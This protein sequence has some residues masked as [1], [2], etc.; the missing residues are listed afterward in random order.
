[1]GI[2][3]AMA[4]YRR[5]IL[6]SSRHHCKVWLNNK[7]HCNMTFIILHISIF[8]RP[9]HVVWCFNFTSGAFHVSFQLYFTYPFVCI[10]CAFG[11]YVRIVILN[12]VLVL[13]FQS[14]V[15][16][17]LVLESLRFPRR[18]RQRERHNS[19]LCFPSKKLT[20]KIYHKRL[21]S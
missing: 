15:D 9:S 17:P 7:L 19:L 18:G 1:M 11:S 20:A 14:W 16:A 21:T 5:T 2:E 10:S 3:H 13:P 4:L 6:P 12:R 8:F